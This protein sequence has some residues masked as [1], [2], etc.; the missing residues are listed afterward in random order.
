MSSSPSLFVS[1]DIATQASILI[2]K[3]SGQSV[4]TGVEL[5]LKN[6]MKITTSMNTPPP[7]AVDAGEM[8]QKGLTV[9]ANAPFDALDIPLSSQTIDIRKA[10]KKVPNHH[11]P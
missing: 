10:Y 2:A 5:L 6:D 1:R 8:L 4:R 3:G 9:L 11:L 7:N